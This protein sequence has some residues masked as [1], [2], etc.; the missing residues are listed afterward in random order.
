MA[1]IEIVER[2][3][4]LELRGEQLALVDDPTAA[5]ALD[6]F[7]ASRPTRWN[8]LVGESRRN[9]PRIALDLGAAPIR[10]GFDLPRLRRPVERPR[11]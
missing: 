1:P 3:P 2:P 8:H 9:L 7:R 11:P 4:M 10:V 6:P 5:S